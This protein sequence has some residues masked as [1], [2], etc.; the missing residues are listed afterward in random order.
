[1]YG[2]YLEVNGHKIYGYCR[3]FNLYKGVTEYFPSGSHFV[4]VG[5]F[6]G[7]STAAMGYL[8]EQSGKNIVFDAVDIFELSEFSDQEHFEVLKEFNND[9][10]GAFKNNLKLAGVEKYVN[11]LKMTSEEA[12]K[13]YEDNSLDFVL[14][15][16][17][18]E[19]KDVKNDINYWLPKIKQGG[20]LA[21]DDFLD[22]KQEVAYAV[23][24]TIG[25]ENIRVDNSTWIH[26]KN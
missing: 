4:E 1:M 16:A 23:R 8:I 9:L 2:H 12:S 21:G 5:S 25:L 3:Y 14:I 19:Y 20:I 22:G 24:D 13:Q 11:I 6:L 17:S 10:F 15:D 26:I 7:Q 18:H